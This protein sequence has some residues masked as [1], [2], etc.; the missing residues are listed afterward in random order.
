MRAVACQC[1]GQII[2]A[3]AWKLGRWDWR[4]IFG[5]FAHDVRPMDIDCIVERK[6]QFLVFETKRANGDVPRGQEI[7]LER[8]SVL[9][10]FTVAKLFGE[11]DVPE[12][13]QQCVNGQ[14]LRPQAFTP[15]DL[16]H[17]CADWWCRV[18]RVHR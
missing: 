13:I 1:K 11:P 17:F 12:R 3:E 15:P 14:W 8:L 10:Q 2:N 16:W 4:P 6:G 5:S 18:N 9:P 7:A